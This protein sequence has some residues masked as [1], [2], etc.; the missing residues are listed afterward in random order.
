MR[1][2][3]RVRL[4]V[5]DNARLD[6]AFGKIER[7]EDWGA[8]VA[9]AAAA[10]GKF[11]AAW[12]EMTPAGVVLQGSMGDEELTGDFCLTCGSARMIR[13]GACKTCADCG[14]SGGCG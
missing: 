12:C 10:T 7:L 14:E 9:T 5:P 8:H 4:V 6:G 13:S 11:R 1:V 2:G 3:D